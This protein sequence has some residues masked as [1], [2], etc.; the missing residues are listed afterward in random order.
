MSR[1][2]YARAELA[3]DERWQGAWVDLLAAMAM[4]F[5]ASLG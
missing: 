2:A 3:R 5:L 4:A 1:S